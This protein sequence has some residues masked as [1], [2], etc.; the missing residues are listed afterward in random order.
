MGRQ[1]IA[2]G[3]AETPELEDVR[4]QDVLPSE[5]GAHMGEAEEVGDEGCEADLS[6]SLPQEMRE[7]TMKDGLPA[8]VEQQCEEAQAGEV[9]RIRQAVLL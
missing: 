9:K 7:L 5:M 8:A 2:S 4:F 3:T 1:V 6:D